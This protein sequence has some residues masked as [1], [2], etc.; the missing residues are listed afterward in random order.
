MSKERGKERWQRQQIWLLGNAVIEVKMEK[1]RVHLKL[2]RGEKV[3]INLYGQ[4]CELTG[5][6]YRTGIPMEWR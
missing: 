4:N 2:K 5:Q 3:K 1:T 6:E